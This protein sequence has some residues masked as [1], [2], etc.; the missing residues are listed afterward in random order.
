MN[1]KNYNVCI[2]DKNQGSFT[3]GYWNVQKK[4]EAVTAAKKQYPGHDKYI[5]I[6][7]RRSFYWRSNA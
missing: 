7:V 6:E 5:A 1:Y 2:S 4:N 3:V